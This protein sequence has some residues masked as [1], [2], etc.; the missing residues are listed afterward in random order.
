MKIGIEHRLHPSDPKHMILYFTLEGT[1]KGVG[2][3]FR[4][5]V[6]DEE[7]M[8]RVLKDVARTITDLLDGR[9]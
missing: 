1:D 6:E 7:D 2:V 5:S 3:A 9:P 8:Y 4:S